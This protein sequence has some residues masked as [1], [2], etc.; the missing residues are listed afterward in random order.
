MTNEAIARRL[1]AEATALAQTGHNL[2]RVR[3]YRQ[4]AIAVLGLDA[5]VE[6]VIAESGPVA[7]TRIPGIGR[8]L[9]EQIAELAKET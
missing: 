7:L 4:A 2:Y 1:R 6:T 9:A 3:A 8:R 5:P